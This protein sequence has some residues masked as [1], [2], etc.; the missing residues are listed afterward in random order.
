MNTQRRTKI[1]C[2]LGPTVDTDDAVR[3]LIS[4]GMNVA[5]LNLSH[6]THQ[7][8]AERV[9]RVRRMS[10]ELDVPVALVLDTKGPEIRTSR[11]S[12]PAFELEREQRIVVTTEEIVGTR[13][14][15]GISYSTLHEEVVP[16]NHLYVADGLIDL[17]V[18]AVSGREISCVVRS[19]GELGSRKNVNIPGIKVRLPSITE[20]DRSDIL[21]AVEQRLDYIAASFIRRPEHVEQIHQILRE[22][23][24]RIRVISKIED[25]EGLENIDEI[26]RVSEGVMVARGD[27]GVQLA[28]QDIPLAQKRIIAKCNAAGKPVITATQMLDS[29][30]ENPR[31]T[32]A[33][34]TD[35]ANAIFDGT[36]AVMLSGETANGRYPIKACQTLDRIARAVEES[37][38]YG[39]RIEAYVG[40]ED[41]QPDIGHAIARATATIADDVQAAA[42]I[43]PSLRGNT[44]R[45]IAKFRPQQ[46]IIAV[47][48]SDEVQRQ[49]LLHWGIV[50]IMAGH[51]TD[52]ETMVQNAIR[53]A[54]AKKLVQI[55]DRV[56]T[57]AG[58]PIR[59]PIPLN[60]IKVH[61]LGTVLN[62]GHQGFG[63][64]CTG[65][66]VRADDPADTARRVHEERA[67][68]LVTRVLT[69][70]FREI[71]PLVVGVILEERSQI[72]PEQMLAANPGLVVISEVPDAVATIE[73]GI[74]V[75][76]D[77]EEQIIYDGDI[78]S[79]VHN[80]GAE[81]R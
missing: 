48:T 3:D 33:E 23:D 5:R 16:G 31:P 22:N 59:S 49:L 47:T 44:P 45:L 64:R 56:V 14:R 4:A 80:R 38:E 55:G 32:R 41:D 78:T 9:D 75:T 58:V 67:D 51:A 19:G 36:D 68:V 8:H 39:E 57:T 24:C 53:T 7:E 52:S 2:T 81:Q 18:E 61:I 71:L 13:E 17:E 21:F 69:E 62:R 42:I 77:G 74:T 27:L 43:A 63:G 79:S 35:V 46:L 25:H 60:T 29:M 26:V 20:K 76:L 65:R 66:I 34:L 73:D 28:V 72:P 70:E 37:Q 12:V 11:L 54:L 40:L 10:A 1:I 6:G 30:I 50:P 15:I